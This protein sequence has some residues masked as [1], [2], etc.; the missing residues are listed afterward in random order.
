MLL[1]GWCLGACKTKANEIMAAAGTVHPEA[2]TRVVC[3]LTSLCEHAI[4]IPC[5]VAAWLL[6]LHGADNITL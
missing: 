1:Q 5:K 3:V 6:A 2:V 4:N